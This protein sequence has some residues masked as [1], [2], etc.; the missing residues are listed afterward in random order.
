MGVDKGNGNL[1]TGT[2]EE[3]TKARIE[4]GNA[5]NNTTNELGKEFG[6]APIITF[7]KS[8]SMMSSGAGSEYLNNL[9]E[10]LKE[11]YSK[12]EQP[13][14][15][16][17]NVTA[18][19][20]EDITNL[21]YSCVVVSVLKGNKSTYFVI[22][23]EATGRKPL[24]A[25]TIVAELSNMN[26]LP[27][28]NQR[29][30][31]IYVTSDAIDNVL[32]SE[33]L[34][35][36]STVS[37]VNSKFYSAEAMVIPYSTDNVTLE[38]VRPISST[39]YNACIVE[40][41]RINKEFRDLNIKE[42]I[43]ENHGT[44]LNIESNM[45]PATIKDAAGNPIRSDFSISLLASDGRNNNES[46]NTRNSD[47]LISK[48]SGFV[49]AMPVEL[50]VNNGYGG[51]IGTEIKLRPHVILTDVSTQLPTIGYGLLALI[52]SVIMVRPNMWLSAVAP[53]SKDALHDSGKLNIITN[54]EKNQSGTGEPIDLTD[55]S[56]T[57]QDVFKLLR[58]MFALEAMFSM[59]VNVYGAQ[60]Y[61]TS[62]FSVAA[63]PNGQGENEAK[64]AAGTDIIE[65]A[66][67]LTSGIFPKN[68]PIEKIFINSAIIVP[69]GKWTD[70]NGEVR[71]LRDIDLS[72]IATNSGD[73]A[74]CND[75]ALSNV[76]YTISGRDP[77]VSKIDVISKLNIKA[78]ITGKAIR[79][80]FS[81][82]FISA[83]S[84]AANRAGFE[85][86]CDPKIDYSEQSTISVLGDYLANAGIS[87]EVTGFARTYQGGGNN[88]QTPW[89]QNQGYYNR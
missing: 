85:T 11:S 10:V 74:L 5:L 19:D 44:Q 30:S 73:V 59:D 72:F 37:P 41:G 24:E 54:L 65:A 66:H 68:F 33:V 9:V 75:W 58:D 61:G 51:P 50:P 45:L 63:S 43:G 84:D 56:I 25:S 89:V 88:Y 12:E 4:L 17:V 29:V 22:V 39:A 20:K 26:R 21:A 62:V 36:L 48:V 57:D 76:P 82:E 81:P 6:E 14:G 53:K 32:N 70:R 46:I 23:L 28:Q 79:C 55:T 31:D 38:N 1:G 3:N 13:S 52:S 16:K 7:N 86:R 15:Y 47:L 40:L 71:D 2:V 35:K 67:W 83:L 18:L 60:S 64:F 69:T 87:Q 49:D 80:T 42:A 78:E 77:Y 34:K 27:H 8:F